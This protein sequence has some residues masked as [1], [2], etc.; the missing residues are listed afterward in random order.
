MTKGLVEA[1]GSKI[2]AKSAG[3]DRGAMFTFTMPKTRGSVMSQLWLNLIRMILGK[4]YDANIV[5]SGQTDIDKA[6]NEIPDLILLD[7]V[8]P[9]T[10]RLEVCERLK[11]QRKTR[12]IALG[13]LTV[14]GRDVG[15]SRPPKPEPMATC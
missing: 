1:H 2:W 6:E 9:G 7:Y 15:R 12:F 4:G 13:I 8:L 14:L 5:T 3:E 11:A 10:G